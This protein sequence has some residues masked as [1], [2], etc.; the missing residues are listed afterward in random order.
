MKDI[1]FHEFKS[2]YMDRNFP[3]I[4]KDLLNLLS[5]ES[6]HIYYSMHYKKNYGFH[7]REKEKQYIH[8]LKLIVVALDTD[9]FI[10]FDSFGK[11]F[12][13]LKIKKEIGKLDHCAGI[14]CY[15]SQKEKGI[16]FADNVCSVIRHHLLNDDFNCFYEII[17]NK[18]ICV[19]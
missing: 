12:F 14:E 19:D 7:Q 1:L 3:L 4:K 17:S 10:V 5:S 15:D 11:D 8:L 9:S 6:E 13:E 18:V 16:Q 2:S